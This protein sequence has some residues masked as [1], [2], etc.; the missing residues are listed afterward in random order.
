MWNMFKVSNKDT[1]TTTGVVLVSL[2]LTL[3]IFHTLFYCSSV[4]VVNF[5]HVN[6]DW[7]WVL[8][9]LQ[10]WPF[11]E[12]L[13]TIIFWITTSFKEKLFCTICNPVPG[14]NKLGMW[15][16]KVWFS[17]QLLKN[18]QMTTMNW[19]VVF[20]EC[21]TENS[22]LKL[23]SLLL[24]KCFIYF[25]ESSLKMMKNAFYFILKALFVLKIIKFLSCFFDHVEKTAWLEI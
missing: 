19:R 10:N 5:K 8:Q 11:W 20:V 22:A 17:V 15:G 23:D 16:F 4:S 3:N 14:K 1:R 7:G 21:L 18:F 9:K 13:Q 2:L 25:N 6:A 24:K 12:D